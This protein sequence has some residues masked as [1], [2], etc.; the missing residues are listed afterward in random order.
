MQERKFSAEANVNND[1]LSRNVHLVSMTSK[2]LQS[3]PAGDV[4]LKPEEA[5]F[6]QKILL[7][8]KKDALD[9]SA[10][11]NEGIVI[12]EKDMA[13]GASNLGTNLRDKYG[14][15]A[16][17][18]NYREKLESR[19][20]NLENKLAQ[21]IA[22]HESLLEENNRFRQAIVE[23]VNNQRTFCGVL[24]KDIFHLQCAFHSEI[25]TLQR[26]FS[27]LGNE[28]TQVYTEIINRLATVHEKF[29]ELIR[30]NME[31]IQELEQR[32]R[33]VE[34]MVGRLTEKITKLEPDDIQGVP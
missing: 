10:A 28:H 22:H 11:L 5:N 14:H 25:E 30:T 1:P 16:L 13:A 15:S 34:G 3:P 9:N 31:R 8:E 4:V 21:H 18:V 20:A 29:T 19:L 7:F 33:R 24:N 17:D 23:E 2:L 26:K 12:P 27:I 32:S 6:L